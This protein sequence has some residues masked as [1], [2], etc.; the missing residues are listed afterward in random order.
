VD[1]EASCPTLRTLLPAVG[2]KSVSALVYAEHVEWS[3]KDLRKRDMPAI[4]ELLHCSSRLIQLELRLNK[5][6]AEAMVDICKGLSGSASIKILDLGANALGMEGTKILAD[7]GAFVSS[8]TQLDLSRNALGA[9]GAKALADGGA[10]K[11]ALS[12]LNLF[13]NHIGQDGAEAIAAAIAASGSMPRTLVLRYNDISVGGA[14]ALAKA[15][16]SIESAASVHVD[17]RSNMVTRREWHDFWEAGVKA[18]LAC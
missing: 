16:T 13:N 3:G 11:G 4:V 10:F 18:Q 14:R 5:L 2:A 9:K 7:G 17:M 1:V 6:G 15:I 12:S 8:L